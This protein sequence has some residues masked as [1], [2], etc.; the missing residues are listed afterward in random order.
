[1]E[2]EPGPVKTNRLLMLIRSLELNGFAMLVLSNLVLVLSLGILYVS[3]LR[4]IFSRIH[5]SNDLRE[6]P[7]CVLILG[8]CLKSNGISDLYRDRLDRGVVLWKRFKNVPI[9]VLGGR[10]SRHPLTEAQAG[11]RYLCDE[12]VN[13]CNVITE[14]RS[15]HT[16]ENL[17]NAKALLARKDY[18]KV[19][20]ITNRYHLHRSSILAQGI[21]LRHLALPAELEWSWSVKMLY[22]V[23]REAYFLHW[24]YVGKWFAIKTRNETMLRRI[25]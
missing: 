4:R 2:S 11:L 9:L 25:T 19:V 10:T 8:K 1:L 20:L 5:N 21:G 7:D 3:I 24:Y 13:P 12:G 22:A 17:K 14:E 6:R 23:C 16:L 15:R 18:H